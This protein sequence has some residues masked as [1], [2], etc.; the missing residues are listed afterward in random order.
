MQKAMVQK[1]HEGSTGSA[2]SMGTVRRKIIKSAA[3]VQLQTKPLRRFI[4]FLAT[5]YPPCFSNKIIP[6]I[7]FR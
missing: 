4:I 7:V 2:G 5:H 1:F 3:E 6:K